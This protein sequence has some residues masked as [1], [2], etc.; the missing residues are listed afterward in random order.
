MPL[1]DGVAQPQVERLALAVAGLAIDPQ[2]HRLLGG[3]RR[4]SP[5]AARAAILRACS[6]CTRRVVLAGREEHG[7]ILRAGFDVLVR[8]V[9]AA[10]T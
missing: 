9:G 4:R 5:P 8:R 10:G 3:I 2:Q 1:I 6:A 7:R